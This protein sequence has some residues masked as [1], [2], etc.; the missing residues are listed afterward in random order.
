[1]ELAAYYSSAQGKKALGVALA[2][3]AALSS[4]QA[5]A[6]Q[7]RSYRHEMDAY[8]VQLQSLGV[9]ESEI[10]QKILAMEK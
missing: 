4:A 3:S 10:D 6:D 2:S 9:S 1:M 5:L 8:I 7:T